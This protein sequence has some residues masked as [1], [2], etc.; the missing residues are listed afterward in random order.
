MEAGKT[1]VVT[2]DNC[3]NLVGTK[4]KVL[5]AQPKEEPSPTT[6]PPPKEPTPPPPKEPTPPLTSE[7]VQK[8]V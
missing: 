1:V 4:V 6:Q 2:E 3:Q 7:K 5:K 8:V